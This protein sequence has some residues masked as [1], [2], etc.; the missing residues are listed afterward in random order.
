MKKNTIVLILFLISTSIFSQS[1]LIECDLV[2]QQNDTTV[3]VMYGKVTQRK[4]YYKEGKFLG[5]QV[6]VNHKDR[7]FQIKNMSDKFLSLDGTV[8]NYDKNRKLTSRSTIKNGK[9]DGATFVYYPSG[10]TRAILNFKNDRFEGLQTYFYENGVVLSTIKW[11]NGAI[12][13][14]EDFFFDNG[15]LF[16][17]KKYDDKNKVDVEFAYYP[18]GKTFL[19][20]KYLSRKKRMTKYFSQNGTMIEAAHFDCDQKIYNN[21]NIKELIEVVDKISNLDKLF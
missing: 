15:A 1:Y 9:L 4:K 20:T 13:G 6:I 18:D 7:S 21:L 3:C 12:V 8:D 10:K 17:S 2:M 5:G 11:E 16:F 19:E 14:T